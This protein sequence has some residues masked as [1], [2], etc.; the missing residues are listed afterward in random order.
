MLELTN[1]YSINTHPDK[2]QK[3]FEVDA[4]IKA[5]F[6]FTE[7]FKSKEDV[8][9]IVKVIRKL[10][11]N[12]FGFLTVD[13]IEEAIE[14]GCAEL[15]GKFTNYDEAIKLIPRFLNAYVSDLQKSFDR[16][17]KVDSKEQELKNLKEGE[18]IF[19]NYILAFIEGKRM[20]LQQETKIGPDFC[21]QT[22]DKFIFSKIKDMSFQNWYISNLNEV[23]LRII[24]IEQLELEYPK[25]YRNINFDPKKD[26]ATISYIMNIIAIYLFLKDEK[27]ESFKSWKK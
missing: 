10:I 3:E 12:K 24:A 11:F 27:K 6:I 25:L 16:Q 17:S 14:N 9:K 5:F 23:K 26:K 7:R 22:F 4:C 15:Y 20:F 2:S 13:Q 19:K 8:E 21:R 18:S 1:N